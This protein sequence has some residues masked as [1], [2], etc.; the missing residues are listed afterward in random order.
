M[1]DIYDAKNENKLGWT[2]WLAIIAVHV[3]DAMK[4]LGT[5]SC[6]HVWERDMYLGRRGL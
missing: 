6:F 5:R 1:S 4:S 3:A 2:L